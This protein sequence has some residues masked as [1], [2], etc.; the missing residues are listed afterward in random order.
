V[1]ISQIWKVCVSALHLGILP[2][3]AAVS[4]RTARH[5]SLININIAQVINVIINPT[6]YIKVP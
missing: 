6:V 1:N 5:H 3:A 4:A 2:E